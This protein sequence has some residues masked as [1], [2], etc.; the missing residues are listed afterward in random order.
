M[1]TYPHT[2][3]NGA[4]ERMTFLGITRDAQGI[5][6]LE[7][8]MRAGPG[9]GPIMHVHRLQEEV[10]TVQS[11]KIGYQRLG[12]EPRFAG[13]GET[14]AFAPGIAH[15]WWNAGTS[16]VYCTGWVSPAYNLEY[17]L[18]ALY[19]SMRE[20]GGGRPGIF[21]VAF[22]ITRYQSE[23]GMLAIP[24]LVQKLIFPVL[25]VLATAL[26]KYE[27]FKD[28]PQPVSL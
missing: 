16:E 4:G 12:D 25:T 17:F 11:G 9:S 5:D 13:E 27:K 14:V 2:I 22:L 28:A 20:N 7:A 26:G 19:Q 23:F 6:R 24:G 15:R 18:T 21:D 3:E 1:H 10:M 8:E